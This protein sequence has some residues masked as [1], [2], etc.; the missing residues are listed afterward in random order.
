MKKFLLL[1]LSLMLVGFNAYATAESTS[2]PSASNIVQA[3]PMAAT[4]P[5]Q[6]SPKFAVF[7]GG[8]FW[9]MESEFSHQKGVS[10]VT[11][12]Y[13]GADEN[14]KQPTYEEVGT[15]TTGF[16]EAISVTYDPAVI[17]YAQLLDI[18]WSNVDP[19]D[20]QGQFCDK[21]TQYQAAIFVSS[22]EERKAAEESLAAVEAKF[23][24][25]VATQ[26]QQQ[27]T[28]FEAEDYHQD[29]Y[30]KNKAKYEL[31]KQGC[32]RT[33]KLES[34]WGDEAQK[35]VTETPITALPPAAPV[36]PAAAPTTT[37]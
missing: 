20:N 22:P 24:R 34:I 31:Y 17:S 16:K 7:A 11:S 37:P 8:C 4:A 14:A 32:G 30:E 10:D 35:I 9:C 29:Y 26:I 21:G 15:G 2:P 3:A 27:V 19:F 12:G 33:G 5:A 18:F 28:F 36:A 13:A 1:T 23:S 6:S 25:K